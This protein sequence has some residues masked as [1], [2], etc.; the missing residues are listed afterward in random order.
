MDANIGKAIDCASRIPEQD[1]IKAEQFYPLW[2][3]G[4]VCYV[5]CDI[6]LI[7]NHF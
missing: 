6:P 2:L 1:K 3:I 7:D 5:F 4:D